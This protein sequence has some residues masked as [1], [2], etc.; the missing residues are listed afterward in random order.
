M[1]QKIKLKL[2]FILILKEIRSPYNRFRRGVE[3][4][5]IEGIR[6]EEMK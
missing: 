2:V 1:R 5:K 3:T 4:L 6:W